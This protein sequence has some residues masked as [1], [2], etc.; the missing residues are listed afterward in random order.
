MLQLLLCLR[1]WS[2]LSL[3]M[4]RRGRGV[5]LLLRVGVLLRLRSRRRGLVVLLRL[6]GRG[7]TLE[8]KGTF[9]FR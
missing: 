6:R 9:R 4:R 8:K 7:E 3:V 2:K 5:L 1:G